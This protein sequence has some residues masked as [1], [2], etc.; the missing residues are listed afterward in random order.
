MEFGESVSG[1]TGRDAGLTVGQGCKY[2]QKIYVNY[3]DW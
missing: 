3:F 2:Y 1:W